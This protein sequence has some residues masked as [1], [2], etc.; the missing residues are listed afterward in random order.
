MAR[1]PKTAATQ[2]PQRITEEVLL[3]CSHYLGLPTPPSLSLSPV[4]PNHRADIQPHQTTSLIW[5]GWFWF[6]E[7]E[8]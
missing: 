6:F 7:V 2:L 5:D 1:S 3:T 4:I 8:V